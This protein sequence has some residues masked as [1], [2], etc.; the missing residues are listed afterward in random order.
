MQVTFKQIDTFVRL[1]ALCSFRR[2]AEEMHTTQPNISNRISQLEAALEMRLFERDAGSVSLTEQGWQMLPLAERVLS[3]VGAFTEA[4]NNMA[5]QLT[6]RLGVAEMVADSWL[7]SYL[8]ALHERYPY[9]VVELSVNQTANLVKE[10]QAR[11]LDLAFLNGPVASYTIANVELGKVAMKWVTCPTLAAKL[12]PRPQAQDLSPYPIMTHAK[13]TRVHV[14]VVQFFREADCLETRVA[15]TNN[16]VACM[17]MAMNGLGIAI[18]PEPL[19]SA[20]VAA[21]KMVELRVDWQPT[22]LNFTASYA[23]S[24]ASTLITSAVSLAKSMANWERVP[25]P[26]GLPSVQKVDDADRQN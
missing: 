21:G 14:E 19:V 1:A 8:A 23:H 16:Q 17:H 25:D 18:L 26:L 5:Y 12:P 22:D 15:P 10:L 11:T 13:N 3:S 2:V 6:L 4:G 24:P 7:H 9:L 20:S